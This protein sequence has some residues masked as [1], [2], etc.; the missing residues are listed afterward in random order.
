[1][2]ETEKVTL[3]ELRE[4]L[5]VVAWLARVSTV[6]ELLHLAGWLT[7][8]AELAEMACAVPE[9]MREQFLASLDMPKGEA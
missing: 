4:A 8:Y 1:M 3:D 2:D 9:E 6:P 5:R 7:H